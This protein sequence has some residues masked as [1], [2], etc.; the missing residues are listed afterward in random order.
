M[1]KKNKQYSDEE[2]SDYSDKEATAIIIALLLP[3]ILMIVALL[4]WA[5]AGML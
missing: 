2:Y 4:L 5:L 1:N 3:T